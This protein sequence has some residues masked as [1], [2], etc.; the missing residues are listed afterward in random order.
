MGSTLSFD[1]FARDRASETFNKV[2]ESAGKAGGKIS[3]FGTQATALAAG[4][5][6]AVGATFAAEF[7]QALSLDSAQAKLSAQLGLTESE[8]QRIGGVAGKLYAGA[9]G[10]SIGEVSDA[11]DAVVSSIDGMRGASAEAVES[12]TAKTLNLATA[13][14][15]DTARAAQVAG[16]LITTGLAKDGTE[17]M[18]LLTASMQRVP[19]A[20]RE[21]LLDAFDE[22]GP[23]LHAVGLNGAQAMELLVK[24]AEKGMYGIDKTGDAIKEFTIRATDMS[25]TTEAAYDTLGLSTQDMTKRLLAGGDTA[26]DAFTTI[27]SGLQNIKDPAKQSQAALALFGTP[28]EDLSTQEIPKFIAQLASSKGAL[29][30]VAGA[31]D[32][33]GQTLNDNAE[34]KLTTFKRTLE[35]NIVGF[36]G[37]V[38]VPALTATGDAAGFLAS[39]FSLLP[40]PS[41]DAVTAIGAIAL[42]VPVAIAAFGKLKDGVQSVIGSYKNMSAVGR[43]SVKALGITALVVAADSLISKMSELNPQVDALGIGLSKWAGGANLSG[44]A[45]RVLGGDVDLL[46]TAFEQANAGGVA[47][48]L[49]GIAELVPGTQSLDT[50]FAKGA[51]RVQ[52]IDQA[53]SDMVRNGHADQAAQIFQTLADKGVASVEDLK[54]ALPGY[55]AAQEV[56]SASTGNA[57]DAQGKSADATRDN[58]SAIGQQ[59]ASLDKLV[60][61]AD[62]AAGALLGDRDAQR[63]FQQAVADA[64]AAFK[65]NGQ[66]LDIHTQKGRDNQAALDGIAK[67]A[68]SEAEAMVQN[69]AT[70][71]QVAGK[72][73]EARNAFIRVATQMGLTKGDATRLADSL[74]LIPGIYDA[75][76]RT[77]ANQEADKVAGLQRSIDLLHGKTVTVTTSFRDVTSPTNL[78]GRRQAFAD[79][80]LAGFPAGG[81]IQGAGGPRTDS[82]LARVSNGE[83]IVNAKSTAQ[84]LDLLHAINSGKPV[85]PRQ[86]LSAAAAAGGVPSVGAQIVQLSLDLSGADRRILDWLKDRIRVDGGGN[87]QVALGQR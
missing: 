70:Q 61:A 27:I 47:K 66:T 84:N 14:G 62:K 25:T 5:G 80:G 59:V 20:V 51:Q 28:L 15:V 22:Y 4:A 67:A 45:A 55:A 21:D 33:F 19:T 57:A 58:T 12:L 72:V 44:E 87:V 10:E 6:L 18:D 65:E 3:E 13:F 34:T 69:G 8:S 16:Q 32:R 50:S 49:G 40:G 2:G 39:G 1:I 60:E 30:D 75:T 9:Y 78:T 24:G 86:P 56:A 36:L 77:N 43:T 74:R 85:A 71:S 42:G 53:L 63:Q 73:D 41:Q 29:G 54:R 68:L 52:A 83:F 79:G 31:A 17:A 38:V 37:G 76:I 82:I 26:R 81:Q 48:F 35:A 64:D 7:A 46:K 11:V 23:F